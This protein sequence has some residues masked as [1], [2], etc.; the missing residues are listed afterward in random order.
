M[1][2]CRLYESVMR[3]ENEKQ[4]LIEKNI[5]LLKSKIQN[6]PVDDNG[7]DS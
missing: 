3:L 5:I 6:R 4:E 7:D 1:L 2:I